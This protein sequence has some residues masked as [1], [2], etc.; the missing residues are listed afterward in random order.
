MNRVEALERLAETQ[1]RLLGLNSRK[2][3]AQFLCYVKRGY[4]MKWFHTAIADACQRLLDGSLGTDKLMVFV[5]PQHGKSEIV[6]RSFP[7]WALG[8]DPSLKIVAASYAFSLAAQFSRSL[9]RLMVSE[10][11]GAVFPRSQL[12]GRQGGYVRAV[13]MFEMVGS[14]GFYKAVGV[15]GA[16]TG[17]PADIGIIDDPIKDA[18]QASSPTYRDRVW[19]WYTDVFLT[20][21]H[22]GSKQLLIQTRWHSDDLAGRILRSE[23]GEWSVLSIPAV[24]ESEGDGALCSGRAIGEPLWPSRHSLEKLLAMK[25]RSPRSFAALYQQR[26]VVEGGN[27]VKRDWFGRIALAEFKALRFREPVHFYLD[28]AYNKRKKSGDNDPSG[29][30]AACLI[31]GTVYLCHAQKVW[32]EMPDL[33]RF[34]PEYMAAHGGCGQSKLNVEPMANGVSVVQMLRETTGL[35]VK[36]TPRPVDSKEVRLRAVS[37]KVECGRVLL[38]E[39][40]WN[41]DF[42]DEVCGFPSRPHDEF[43][44]ILGYAVNDLLGGDDDIDYGALD[45]SCLGF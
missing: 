33:L 15:G 34:L 19:E 7:A 31:R 17:T 13:D 28:T 38:V 14:G 22:N 36:E 44:D 11:Y 43:V 1:S 16:L 23:G 3:F 18:L 10:H 26:P 25:G 5:P 37:P 45:K 20:R 35:N 29:I 8:V 12:G 42:L 32:K 30:L 39:G 24:C 6:S 27:I 4:E 9:Q 21:L 40:A 41:E 2:R